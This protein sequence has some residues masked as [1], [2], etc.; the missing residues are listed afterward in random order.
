MR[1]VAAGRLLVRLDGS[2]CSVAEVGGK[3]A[4]LDRLA[5]HGFPV[6]RSY[7]LIADAYRMAVTD[8]GLL[9][10]LDE[11]A[12][13]PAPGPAELESDE[14]AIGDRFAELRLPDAV[15][16]DVAMAAT[17]LLAAGRVAVRSSATA[18]DTGAASF[19]G[20]YRTFTG[21]SHPDHVIAAVA[22]C[23]ASLWSPSARTYRRRHGIAEDDL[24]MAVVIQQMVEAHWSGVAFTRD[25]AG[26]P[27]R[28]RIEV[29][30]GTGDALVSGAVTPL[31]FT[32]DRESLVV[33]TSRGGEAPGFLETLVRML[34][35]VED[36]L[37]A[38]QD[39]EWS[40]T[41]EGIVLLQ[42][43][44]VTVGGPTAALDD[45]LDAPTGSDDTFTAHGVVEMLPGV[46]PPLLWTINAPMIESGLRA[47]VTGLGGVAAPPD[48]PL[49]GRFRGR[50]AMNLSA[51]RDVAASLPGGSPAAVE[52]QFLGRVISDGDSVVK[53]PR[54]SAMRRVGRAK[55]RLAD[56]V[57]LV[58]GA[59]DAVVELN[60][61]LQR[62]P[63]DR[64][65]VYS[66]NVRDLA[67][68]IAAAEVA[69][70]SAAAAAYQTLQALLRRWVEPTEA[71]VLAQQLTTG[72]LGADVAGHRLT[73][74][75]SDLWL[76]DVSDQPDLAMAITALPPDRME[77]SLRQLGPRGREVADRVARIARL[78]GSL[79]IYGG[80]A[81]DEDPHAVWARM[82][83]LARAASLHG[84][85]SAR[86]TAPG[87]PTLTTTR[88]WR[89]IRVL[90]G[91]IVDLRRRWI[92]RQAADAV[93]WLR[94]REQAKTA[95]LTLGGE[96]R[97]IIAECGRRLVASSHLGSG[98][99]IDLYTDAEVRGMLLGGPPPA[100]PILHWR[101]RAI[102]RCRRQPPLPELF[103]GTPDGEPIALSPDTETMAGWAASPG[104]VS[105]EARVLG[106]IADADRLVPGEILV[107]ESTDPSWT[108]VLA[109]AGGL[110]LET[111]GPLS[112][113][114]IV[115][116][117]LGIPAVLCVAGATSVI[118]D[119][120]RIEVDGYAGVVRRSPG[121]G[122]STGER[123]SEVGA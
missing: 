3:A 59:A 45:G 95:L 117:E 65:A 57:A 67:W 97:R 62:L 106:S 120:D 93:A 21:L 8:G 90:T 111:G 15:V 27:D 13:R 11:V 72:A 41:P 83:Q 94:R 56:E 38:P 24:A 68:R 91:Q 55:R 16:S 63:A 54:W 85:T 78:A 88:R 105:A 39:V 2:G 42:A 119:G 40:W 110:V 81:W 30:P 98:D 46:V 70:S 123:L 84:P 31:D 1:T 73:S 44:P 60:V 115:A 74:A 89:T 77:S 22:R 37:D 19:A 6:P 99:D 96:E 48:R 7:A 25:P 36:E 50:A 43:R 35:R 86:A 29:V 47:V 87:A 69:A 52:E 12:A 122:E 32:V 14:A 20:Q 51:L 107:A 102:E 9:P 114:A 116:R 108:P 34:L 104:R 26:R 100:Q 79:A 53:R 17:D 58:C 64:L 112:H 71:V 18:E 4:G 80:A 10:W 82:S 75:L 5:A 76:Q 92:E 118:A 49:I 109:V 101:R 66:S 33:V 23:W 28:L 113:A 61:V 103:T 121:A